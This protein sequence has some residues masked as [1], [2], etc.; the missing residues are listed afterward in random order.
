MAL[1]GSDDYFFKRLTTEP[2]LEIFLL[3]VL[4]GRLSDP[5][6]SPKTFSLI[7]NCSEVL[8]EQ[9]HR[10]KH[11]NVSFSPKDIFHA[12]RM[13]DHLKMLALHPEASS[14]G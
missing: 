8:D 9:R 3:A 14:Y 1:G 7:Q 2:L 5:N 4:S 6:G 11:T 12:V 10:L 13:L